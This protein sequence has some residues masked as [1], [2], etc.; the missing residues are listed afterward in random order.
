MPGAAAAASAPPPA[1]HAGARVPLSARALNAA[2]WPEGTLLWLGRMAQ[3][4]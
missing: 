1:R 3:V 4:R 2:L